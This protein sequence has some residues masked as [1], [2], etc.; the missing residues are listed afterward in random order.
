MRAART[1]CDVMLDNHEGLACPKHTLAD[2]VSLS[3]GY[4][5]ASLGASASYDYRDKRLTLAVRCYRAQVAVKLK[6]SA[7]SVRAYA[8]LLR[9]NAATQHF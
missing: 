5:F 4:T 2:A 7:R 1:H 8:L 3:I 9:R 6:N